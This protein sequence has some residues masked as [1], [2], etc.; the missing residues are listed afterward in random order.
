MP[1]ERELYPRCAWPESIP[2]LLHFFAKI[3]LCIPIDNKLL[4]A[5]LSRWS[6]QLTGLFAPDTNAATTTFLA[7]KLPCGLSCCLSRIQL[8]SRPPW[9]PTYQNKPFHSDC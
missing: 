9:H 7:L 6:R 1:I 8:S 3:C 2:I 5:R 4:S